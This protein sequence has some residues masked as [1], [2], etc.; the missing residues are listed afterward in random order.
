MPTRQ[1]GPE[2]N[3]Y[4]GS[5]QK[6]QGA[7]QWKGGKQ[8]HYIWWTE[9][10]RRSRKANSNIFCAD[11]RLREWPCRSVLL[12]IDNAGNPGGEG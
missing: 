1:P 6:P 4:G 10:F 8:W 2:V 3:G 12:F 11:I 5:P 7:G 9:T